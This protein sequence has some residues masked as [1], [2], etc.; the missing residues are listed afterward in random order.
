MLGGKILPVMPSSDQRVLVPPGDQTAYLQM[1]TAY[2]KGGI[3]YEDTSKKYKPV[4]LL[5]IIIIIKHTLN[6][7]ISVT[8]QVCGNLGAFI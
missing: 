3:P 2:C 8:M 7:I 4:H 5:Y 1:I 6:T